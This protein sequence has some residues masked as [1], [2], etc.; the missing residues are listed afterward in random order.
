[1]KTFKDILPGDLQDNYQ[2]QYPNSE[3][4]LKDIQHVEYGELRQICA[5]CFTN[6]N[7]VFPSDMAKLVEILEMEI[8]LNEKG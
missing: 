3:L 8:M 6:I 1:M 4:L 5:G 2:R 7:C